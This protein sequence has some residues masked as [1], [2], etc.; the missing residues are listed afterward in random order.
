MVD[1]V[2]IIFKERVKALDV[3]EVM[4]KVCGGVQF[5]IFQGGGEHLAEEFG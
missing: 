5:E 2:F 4:L 3:E 1:G